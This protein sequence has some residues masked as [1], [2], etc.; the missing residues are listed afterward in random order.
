VSRQKL[1]AAIRDHARAQAERVRP[2][3]RARVLRAKPLK[4]ELLSGDE[5]LEEDENLDVTSSLNTYIERVGLD[6]DDTVLV[7]G[8]DGDFTAFD[9]IAEEVPGGGGNGS[10]EPGPVGPMGPQGPAGP[11]GPNGAD[12]APGPAGSTGATGPMGPAGPTGPASTVPGPQGPA[13]PTGP[14]GVK[15]DTGATGAGGATGPTGPTGATGSQGPTG[16]Q[17]IQGIQGIQGVPGLIHRGAWVSGTAYL[18]NDAVTYG[19]SLWRSLTSF[20]STTAPPNDGANWAV[21][22]S[23]GDTGPMG[24]TGYDTAPIGMPL[25]W[26][27]STLPDGYVLA[28]GQPL[29]STTYPQLAAFALAEKNAGNTAWTHSG[30]TFT[31]P[32]MRNRFVYGRGTK[33]L[34]A[35]GGVEQYT[36]KAAEAAQKA[37]STT[38]STSGVDSPDHSHSNTN[39]AFLN[40]S[41]T[42]STFLNTVNN[43]GY[44]VFHAPN[45]AG[46]SVRHQHSIPALSIAGSDATSPHENMPPYV[47]I[48]WI[49]KAKGATMS[50]DVITGPP[51]PVGYDTAPIGATIPWSRKTLPSTGEWVLA[52]GARY[53][54][55]TYPQGYAAAMAEADAGNPLWTYRTSDQTFTVPNLTDRFIYGRDPANMGGTGGSSTIG[56][57]HLPPHSHTGPSHSHGTNVGGTGGFV[58]AALGG[59]AGWVVLGSGASL[60]ITD[61]TSG[62]SQSTGLSGTGP[63]GNGPGTSAQFLPPYVALAQIVKIKGVSI[64]GDAIVGPAGPAGMDGGQ[65]FVAPIGDGS[66]RAFTVTHNL[67]SKALHTTVRQSVAPYSEVTAEVEYASPNTVVVRTRATD[68]PP[69]VAQYVVTVSGAGGVLTSQSIED[70]HQVGNPGE[71]AFAGTWVNRTAGDY[72]VAFRKDPLGRV[73]IR[74]YAENPSMT[75]GGSV[76]FTLPVGYRPPAG[77][78]HRFA[79]WVQGPAISSGQVYVDGATGTVQFYGPGG[80]PV[81]VDLA[82]VEFDTDS[83]TALPAG[84]KGVDGGAAFTQAI[85]DGLARSFVVNHNLGTRS[86]QISVFDATTLQDVTAGAEIERTS[87]VSVTVRTSAALPPPASGQY[88][89]VVSAPGAQNLTDQTMDTWHAVGGV[90]EPAFQNSWVNFGAPYAAAAFRKDPF[91]RVM[92]RGSIKSGTINQTAFTLPAGYRPVGNQQFFIPQGTQQAGGYTGALVEITPAGAVGIYI[93]GTAT[94]AYI[95]LASVEFDTDTVTKALAGPKG[96]KGDPG[97]LIPVV[98]SL[99]PTPTDGQEC[100]F[101]ADAANGVIWRL[102][103]RAFQADGV[104][105]NPSS[106]KWECIGGSAL[107]AQITTAEG[108]LSSIVTDLATVGPSI[109]IPLAGEYEFTGESMIGTSAVA[110]AF[111]DAMIVMGPVGGPFNAADASDFGRGMDPASTSGINAQTTFHR[112]RTVGTAGWLTKLQYRANGT[113]SVTHQNRR[114]TALPVRVG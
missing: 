110:G 10:G 39:G 79:T 97:Y 42:V 48:V 77:G 104:T 76:I 27:S 53:S 41:A 19:G 21:L 86:V 109:T 29:T 82:V 106:Y 4:L 33:A 100:C 55:T 95:D 22:A 36:L 75:T 84:P 17:G 2:V 63:T 93:T 87:T 7:I 66:S 107:A 62:A 49:I 114:L 98:T 68:P 69:T 101:L 9:V 25:P 60:T 28:D 56:T 108:T 89:V 70:W 113:S 51:G 91:G 8:V 73:H 34:G 64:S 23:K 67:G 31:A 54:Q 12:G 37:T 90:G 112:R 102:R 81:Y 1:A 16:P 85:G 47:V 18:A 38:A 32:D 52:D 40:V 50:A 88:T 24:P 59:P 11:A 92:L 45:T 71:P 14:Q 58:T 46:A 61:P 30:A 80:T 35:T 96:D 65:A 74:G 20:T 43:A 99:P 94:N 15:G 13:G 72:K 44:A 57:A 103:Y 6:K 5:I 83:V 105:P 3:Q 26:F 78:V 111:G